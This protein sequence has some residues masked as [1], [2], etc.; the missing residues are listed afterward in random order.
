MNEKENI[1][2][3]AAS[4]FVFPNNSL[5][6]SGKI[7]L[8]CNVR[9]FSFCDINKDF[10]FLF[11][12]ASLPRKTNYKVRNKGKVSFRCLLHSLT[13]KDKFDSLLNIR[14]VAWFLPLYPYKRPGVCSAAN[15]PSP[16]PGTS[17]IVSRTR[18]KMIQR[19]RN[20]SRGWGAHTPSIYHRHSLFS[21]QQ[22]Y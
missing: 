18:G 21:S 6:E 19:S 10:C 1:S 12:S 17:Q 5:H 7:T 8:Y 13:W 11:S 9:Y 20:L 14:R 22:L 16:S 4:V 2:D 15:D 3:S